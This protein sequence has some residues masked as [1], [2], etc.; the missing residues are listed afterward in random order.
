MEYIL[1]QHTL[2]IVPRVNPTTCT[3]STGVGI[4]QYSQYTVYSVESL[5]HYTAQSPSVLEPGY[6]F[7]G[8]S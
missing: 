5:L 4:W 6:K 1:V 8:K 7:S 3:D 2:H